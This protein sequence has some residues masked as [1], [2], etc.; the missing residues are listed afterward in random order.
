MDGTVMRLSLHKT[1]HLEVLNRKVLASRF[2]LKRGSNICH[3]I[4]SSHHYFFSF[5][6]LEQRISLQDL[7][8]A[9]SITVSHKAP[10]LL[11]LVWYV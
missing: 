10:A 1:P 5:R 11:G 7:V 4:Y 9:I 2:S 8:L 3:G 6:I